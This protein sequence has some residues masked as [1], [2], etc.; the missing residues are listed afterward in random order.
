M[1]EIQL[2]WHKGTSEQMFLC[3]LAVPFPSVLPKIV[4]AWPTLPVPSAFGDVDQLL[5]AARV[6]QG[7]GVL[8]VPAGD[9]VQGAT[10]GRHRLVRQQ[11]GVSSG[12]AVDQ[13]P[14]GVFP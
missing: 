11:G 6:R 4:R 5:D 14:H 8:H 10:D 1:V 9:L 2:R 3:L 13:V 7:L 12:E